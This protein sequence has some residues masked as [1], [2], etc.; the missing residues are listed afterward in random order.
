MRKVMGNPRL[1]YSTI[2]ARKHSEAHIDRFAA[3]P[4]QFSADRLWIWPRLN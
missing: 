4:Y 2:M 3:V 1:C